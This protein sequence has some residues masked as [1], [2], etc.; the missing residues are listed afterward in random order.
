MNK[1][2]ILTLLAI[3]M[4]AMCSCG[5]SGNRSNGSDADNT[6]CKF[7]NIKQEKM[8]QYLDEEGDTIFIDNKVSF[9]WPTV[10]N[11]KLCPELQ[12]SLLRALT[13]SAE[14]NTVDLVID[15][16]LKPDDDLEPAPGTL[17]P[18]DAITGQ[19]MNVF[20]SELMLRMQEMGERLLTYHIHRYAYMGGAHGIYSNNF[21]TYDQETEKTIAL[22]DIIA[23]T[24]LL[25]NTT[26]KSIK[27]AYDYD[28]D[29]L[30]L[31]ENGLLPL[32]GDF[33]IEDNVLHVVYQV[34]EI[35]S[36]AQ[37]MID[38]PIYPYMLK[39]EETK[40]LFTPYGLELMEYMTE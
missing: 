33:Y 37:G 16:L 38:A 28:I 12:N 39:P 26:L 25:R 3:L 23:D 24:T 17:K 9:F 15:A 30:F 2:H 40:R 29:D 20:S 35:A 22:S 14:L 6:L 31:P 21:V 36:Y 32:P 4:T 27:Q 10:I 34:Y 5:M 7:N 13:D 11:G 1:N 19:G 8:Y 18:V